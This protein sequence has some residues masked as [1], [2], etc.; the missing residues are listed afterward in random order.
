M[1]KATREIIM[2]KFF[3]GLVDPYAAYPQT[4]APP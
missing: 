4:D 2:F 1:L 3:E